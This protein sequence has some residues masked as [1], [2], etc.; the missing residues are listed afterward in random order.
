MQPARRT[1]PYVTSSLRLAG[2][3]AAAS[4]ACILSAADPVRAAKPE[5]AYCQVQPVR[6]VAY[7]RG[8]GSDPVRHKLDLYLPKGEKDF[9]VVLFVHGGAWLRGDKSFLGVYEAVGTFLA[10]QGIGAAVINYRLSPAVR[11]PEHIRDVARAF[12]WTYKHIAEYGGRPDRLF[13]CGHSAG[14]H[15]VALL[16]TDPSWLKAE[17]LTTADIRGVIG[18]SG[19]YDLTQL[20]ERFASRVFGAG[21][22]VL[23]TA[24]PTRQARA[25]L[26]P[27][28]LLYADKD[29]PGCGKE[30]A[31]AFA[32]ALREKGTKVTTRE[33]TGSSHYKMVLGTVIPGDPESEAILAFITSVVGTP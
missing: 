22:A 21:A 20:P 33:M 29:F 9:P 3:L 15:L 30:P 16:A 28:L 19:V 5:V 24:S 11:H 26:P 12:A 25:G 1:T 10:R 8:P 7:F 13:V 27:F 17:G 23:S 14:G 31:E 6:D 4:L 2:V 18:I 32:K